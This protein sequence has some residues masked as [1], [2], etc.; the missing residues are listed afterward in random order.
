M[1]V[2]VLG[3]VGQVHPAALR[4]GSIE[5]KSDA[6]LLFMPTPLAGMGTARQLA[7]A[8]RGLEA[9]LDPGVVWGYVG[10][11]VADGHERLKQ[12]LGPLTAADGV[13][14]RYAAATDAAETALR[15][16]AERGKRDRCH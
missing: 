3:E 2:E 16:L 8:A 14:A 6:V 10:A 11:P 1:T 5:R 15:A 12:P 9:A 13:E 7:E 4:S